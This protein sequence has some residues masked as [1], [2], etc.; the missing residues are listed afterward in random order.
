LELA[1]K[2]R[3]DGHIKQPESI[4]GFLPEGNE[5]S[6]ERCQLSGLQQLIREKPE[7]KLVRELILEELKTR[8]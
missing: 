2:I 6:L 8:D 4:I 3:L 1:R 7:P 5:L